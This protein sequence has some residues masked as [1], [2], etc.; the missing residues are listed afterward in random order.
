MGDYYNKTR[1]PLPVTLVRGGSMCFAPKHWGY[2]RPE[3]EGSESLFE[4]IRNGYLV[5]SAVPI[6]VPAAPVLVPES[7]PAASDHVVASETKP[8]TPAPVVQPVVAPENKS[9]PSIPSNVST[10]RMVEMQ[11]GSRKGR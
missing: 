10:P 8:A 7:V 3:D 2:I 6:I 9:E 11:R 5:R 4:A 1:S